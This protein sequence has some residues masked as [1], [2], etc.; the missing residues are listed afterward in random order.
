MKKPN[1]LLSDYVSRL[2]DE[3][4]KDLGQRLSQRL[5]GDYAEVAQFLQADQEVDKWLRT[6]DSATKW[7][8][9]VD[10]IADFVNKEQKRRES[11]EEVTV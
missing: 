2:S 5:C 7:F 8:E 4:V 9:M 3:Q 10:K 1:A 11:L 6:A